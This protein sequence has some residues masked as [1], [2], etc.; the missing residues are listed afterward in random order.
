M[1]F[2]ERYEKTEGMLEW[3]ICHISLTLLSSYFVQQGTEFLVS[4]GQCQY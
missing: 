2:N 4:E 3:N 1:A